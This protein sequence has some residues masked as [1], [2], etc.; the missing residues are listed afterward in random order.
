MTGRAWYL[1][2]AIGMGC[3]EY[4]LVGDES[5]ESW[6]SGPAASPPTIFHLVAQG[7]FAGTWTDG[8]IDRSAP[9][10]KETD[11]GYDFR[12]CCPAG[13]TPFGFWEPDNNGGDQPTS[14]NCVEDAPASSP[15]AVLHVSAGLGHASVWDGPWP[16]GG[17]WSGGVYASASCATD[18]VIDDL[19][20]EVSN[21]P[22]DFRDCCP[23]GFDVAGGSDPWEALSVT[24]LE[25]R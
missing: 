17:T 7:P 9:C 16:A 21:P 1:L 14:V 24:C 3:Q 18:V 23:E 25:R 11:D 4:A 10:V 5:V 2:S 6:G 19:N 13:F 15:R 12:R 20:A 22:D 8:V